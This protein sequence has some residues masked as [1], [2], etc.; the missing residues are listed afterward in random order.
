[1]TTLPHRGVQEETRDRAAKKPA[2]DG[3]GSF[4]AVTSNHERGT[5]GKRDGRAEASALRAQAMVYD[6][7]AATSNHG[8]PLVHLVLLGNAVADEHKLPTN[9]LGAKPHR[10]T[11]VTQRFC[12]SARAVLATISNQDI[13]VDQTLLSNLSPG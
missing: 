7:G 13:L 10:E 1:M 2:S 4:T 6:A 12:F 11:R 3:I 8:L 5:L 9:L